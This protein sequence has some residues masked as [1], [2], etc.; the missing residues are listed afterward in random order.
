MAQLKLYDKAG[1]EK[2][3]VTLADAV[4]AAEIKEHLF[5]E[6]VKWQ[7]A[8]RRAGTSS[9][10]IRNEVRGSNAKPFKQK[11]TGR[12]RR[13][14]LKKSPL[15]PGGGTVHG[16]RPRDWSYRLNRKVRASALRSALSKR[17]SE[18]RLFVVDDL[19]LGEYRTKKVL[20]ILGGFG[21]KGALFVD[22]PNAEL[23][24]SSRN[25]PH[26]SYL[27]VD[28]LNVYDVLRHDALV[29]SESAVRAAEERLQR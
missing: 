4:F 6:V 7:L 2:G 11:G 24:R 26:T 3:E 22:G 19:S 25:L 23:D 9:S 29:I 17:V 28:G 10:K 27:R 8:A 15:V 21:V 14:V 20:E 12:A 1:K 18:Q 16:P 5:Q 13:G